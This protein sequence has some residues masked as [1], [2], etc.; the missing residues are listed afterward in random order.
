MRVSVLLG[1]LALG[2]FAS[3]GPS[4]KGEASGLLREVLDPLGEEDGKPLCRPIGQIH[5]ACTDYETAE[6]FNDEYIFAKLDGLR[7]TPYFRYFLVDLFRECPF[8]VDDGL[9]MNRACVVEKMNET[10]VPIEFR[11]I[12]LSELNRSDDDYKRGAEASAVSASTNYCK[13]DEDEGCSDA[14]YVDLM[15][16][17]ERFTGYSGDSA[18]RVW[19]SIYEEN[20]FGGV[21]YIEPPKS[22]SQG[23]TGFV[24]KKQIAQLE[25]TQ[26]TTINSPFVATPQ[27]N[28]MLDAIQSP[29]D[30][31]S[32]EQCLEKRVFYRI[33]SG[34][35]ASIS[36][37]ICNEYLDPETGEWAPNLECFISRISQH[38]ERLQNVYFNYVLIL[39]ALSKAG[40]FIDNFG[41]LPGDD[42]RDPDTK[43]QL[44]DLLHT[45]QKSQP[46]FDEHMLF[47]I[48][49]NAEKDAQTLAL[50][51]DFRQHFMNISRI[52]DCV[53]CDKCRLWGKIQISGIG[54]A[55]KLLFS[56]DADKPDNKV[57]IRRSELVALI[58]TAHRFSESLNSLSTFRNMYQARRQEN[59]QETAKSKKPSSDSPESTPGQLSVGVS[60]LRKL[61]VLRY[62]QAVARAAA[63]I[64]SNTTRPLFLGRHD[65]L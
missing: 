28:R 15:K 40:E 30:A 13:L 56:F 12:T 2:A 50:K 29:I 58:N 57:V 54:T 36:I 27:W 32:T 64:V 24:G 51:E 39:R 22:K 4:T 48:Q 46:A 47:Q 19:R 63:A 44:I 20:C 18:N 8:W 49:N 65:E 43:Q 42:I 55:L 5:D 16:N 10:E 62:V 34:L 25:D 31:A 61:G 11:P 33:I 1:F 14:V 52:M 21:K 60:L 9:C 23:G 53:G 17:P 6:S 26:M 45:A 41:L 38:P 35:H 37:H 59:S 3:P 7:R